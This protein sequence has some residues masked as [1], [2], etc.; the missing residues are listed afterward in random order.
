[1]HLSLKKMLIL[2]FFAWG[3]LFEPNVAS[4]EEIVE[5]ALNVKALGMGNAY[6]SV[7][8]GHDAVFY[9]PA[10]LAK[11][12]GVHFRLLSVGAG[13]NG[14]DDVYDKYK[15][16]SDRMDS[17]MSGVLGELYGD[18]LWGRADGQ[19]SL[20]I[21]SVILGVFGRSNL[22]FNLTNPAF[23][24]LQSSF[25]ADYG[26]FAGF[27]LEVVPDYVDFGAVVKR[28]QRE[29]GNVVLGP[30]DLAS[31]DSD[32]I[33]EHMKKRGKGYGVDL[34]INIKI[35]MPL[36]PT[37]S[38]AWQNVGKTTFNVGADPGNA[39][40]RQEDS[41]NYG[42]GIEQD[43]TVFTFRWAVDYRHSNLAGEQ[44]GKKLH[45]GIELDFPAVT[46]RGGFN[47]GYYTAGASIDFFFFQ[48]DAAT[49]GV[50]LGAFP[51]QQQDR[52]YIVQL[53]MEFGFD[54]AGNLINLNR[55]TRRSGLKQRR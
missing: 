2:I 42:L 15:D 12:K 37:I 29:G 35:P 17:D 27:G 34:G 55:N 16:M 22:G 31:M 23:P 38:A 7:A 40:P 41:I 21:G 33:E 45:T 32:L 50:E 30:G 3:Y 28:I 19:M 49:Y 20:S 18:P 36:N 48:I 52:R 47:Q 39:P 26:A 1:M 25:F 13:L 8:Q 24:Q 44:I 14:L 43:L 54:S 46:L 6:L 9:N 53:L 51:G 11:L 4:A 5:E 10:G